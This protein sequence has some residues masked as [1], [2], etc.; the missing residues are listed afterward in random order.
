M[1]IAVVLG[2]ILALDLA[3]W[4]AADAFA[5][6]LRRRRLWRSVVAVFALVQIALVAAVIADRAYTDLPLPKYADALALIWH[7]ILLPLT[8]I[9]YL[10]AAPAAVWSRPRPSPVDGARPA[11]GPT[12]RAFLGTLAV[13]PPAA[14]VVAAGVGVWQTTTFRVR[15]LT[16]PLAGLPPALDGL[17]IAHVTD[18]HVGELTN[19]PI[20]G[21]IAD[22]V[23]ALDVDLVAFTGD[24]INHDLNA[25]PAAAEMMNAM[26]ARHGVYL[27][28]GN[29]DL[30]DGADV[31]D[32]AAW[33]AGLNLLVNQT[34]RLSINGE[35]VDL[36]GLRWG[37]PR[38]GRPTDRSY[39]RGD[40][41]IAD[42]FAEIW[43]TY[44]GGGFPILLAH[45]PHAFDF[46]RA[47][48]VPLTLSG[49][50]HGGQLMLPGGIGFGPLM[51]R[52]HSGLYERDGRATVVSNG[53]GNWFPLRTFAPAEIIHLTLRR[54]AP[55]AT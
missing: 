23:N 18:T 52:Y 39:E 32:G 3:W 36:L 26:T 55:A 5:R 30:F 49:H 10:L 20:L 29:H 38:D 51:Y 13:A 33:E 8:L 1:F 2:V 35:N 27:V 16:V 15:R 11:S 34:R 6:P 31:F 28:E 50:T 12:R 42:S 43:E 9:A 40:T 46:A 48:G 44:A 45:H 53:T 19:G 21:D 47:K 14:A 4:A 17:T 54:A 22:A 37:G 7:L 41:A 24:L 25:L